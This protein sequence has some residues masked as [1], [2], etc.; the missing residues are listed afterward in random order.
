MEECGLNGHNAHIEDGGTRRG[1]VRSSV[2]CSTYQPPPAPHRDVAKDRARTRDAL[3]L[4]CQREKNK[5]PETSESQP[6]SN[7]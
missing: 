1:E 7:L 2:T 3:Q 5:E 6:I 4:L